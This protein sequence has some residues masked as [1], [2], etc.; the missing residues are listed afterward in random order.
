MVSRVSNGWINLER[1][2]AADLVAKADKRFNRPP[3][4]TGIPGEPSPKNP[5]G[6]TASVASKPARK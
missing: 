2:D 1:R 4:P 6:P 3:T 5:D